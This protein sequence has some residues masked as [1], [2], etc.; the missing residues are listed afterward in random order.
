MQ[1]N[2]TQFFRDG[3]GIR[4]CYYQEEVRPAPNCIM[5]EAINQSGA[6]NFLGERDEKDFFACFLGINEFGDLIA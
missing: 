4:E 1:S 3:F 5:V 2:L 6:R